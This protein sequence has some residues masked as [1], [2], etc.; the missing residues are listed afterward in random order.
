MLHLIHGFIIAQ[1]FLMGFRS[2]EYGGKN[3]NLSPTNSTPSFFYKGYEMRHYHPVS[4][5]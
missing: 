2:D 5:F 3:T 4:G 1:N